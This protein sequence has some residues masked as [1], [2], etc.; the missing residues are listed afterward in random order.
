MCFVTCMVM[1]F[2]TMNHSAVTNHIVFMKSKSLKK[3]SATISLQ[4]HLRPSKSKIMNMW[5]MYLA[6]QS[7]FRAMTLQSSPASKVA[8]QMWVVPFTLAWLSYYVIVVQW[9]FSWQCVNLTSVTRLFFSV[10]GFVTLSS[11]VLCQC[12][13]TG[14][15]IYR[16]TSWTRV[17][18][19]LAWAW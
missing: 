3:S 7:I 15:N 17:S 11:R 2:T 16:D 19:T 10:T 6:S 8:N 12:R 14:L 5:K 9:S 4:S 18:H 13:R 1:F